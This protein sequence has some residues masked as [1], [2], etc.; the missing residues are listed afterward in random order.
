MRIVATGAHLTYPHANGFHDDRLV[1]TRFTPGIG[2]TALVSVGWPAPAEERLVA[3]IAPRRDGEVRPLY[4]DVARDAGTTVWVWDDVLYADGE[5]VHSGAALQ[6]LVSITAD[7]RSVVFAQEGTFLRLDLASGRVTE[8]F[9]KPWFANHPHLS[10]YD[11]TWLAF[12]HEGPADQVSDRVWA[13]HDGETR[14][15]LD[16]HALADSGFVEVGHER[17]LFHDLGAAV[18]GYGQSAAGPRGLYFA[19]PDG[20][21]PVLI[22]AHDRYWHCD[23]SRDGRL[24]TVDTTGPADLPGRG[25][26][27]AGGRSDVLLIEV[28][29]GKAVRLARTHATT[30]P[31]H[32]H[33]VFAPDGDAVLFNHTD[34]ATGAVTVAYSSVELVE[35]P[36]P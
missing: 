3:T 35:T 20:R 16:Q 23:V 14:C 30:H 31:N 12:S 1:L 29:T 5:P 17:W 8:L 7:G 21:A 36:A 33:P 19:Y 4:P 11:E 24:A 13:W 10:P 6:G 34:P 15:V 25:W 32:P 9:T 28:A 27:D 22:S 18:V 26:Q 2:A